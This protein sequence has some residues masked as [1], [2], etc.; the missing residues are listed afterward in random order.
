MKRAPA[1]CDAANLSQDSLG[2]DGEAR[3]CEGRGGETCPC[4]AAVVGLVRAV[5]LS[6]GS[7]RAQGTWGVA[8]AQGAT[9]TPQLGRLGFEVEPTCEAGR[10]SGPKLV[11][12][13]RGGLPAARAARAPRPGRQGQGTKT[14]GL[15]KALARVPHT[16][17]VWCGVRVACVLA[18]L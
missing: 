7:L 5:R 1:T 13:V 12:C 2:L 10:R 9:E 4:Q 6:W 17:C 8:L 3:G 18:C 14:Q 15:C 11:L 16:A